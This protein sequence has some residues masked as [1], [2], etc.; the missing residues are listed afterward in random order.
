MV[1]VTAAGVP[2]L[3]AGGVAVLVGVLS[4]RDSRVVPDD[5][6]DADDV[7]AADDPRGTR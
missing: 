1:P 3:A 5:V 7:D 2:V 6:D 4:R